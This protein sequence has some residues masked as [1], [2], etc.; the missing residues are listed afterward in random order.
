MCLRACRGTDCPHIH[1]Y[2]PLPYPS[3]WPWLAPL[4]AGQS[5]YPPL[6]G[7]LC[8]IFWLFEH[9]SK[10]ASKKHR[11][12]EENILFWFPKTHPKPPPNRIKIDVPKNIKIFID[13]RWIFAA[14]CKSRTLI[15][16]R[17]AMV[18][19]GFYTIHAFAFGMR[20]GSQNPAPNPSK[21]RPEPFKH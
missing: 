9:P 20:F 11:K 10:F 21:T 18:L 1:E 7:S 16:V 17:M 6:G 4:L 12:N 3:P 8:A 2:Q 5:T 13:F 14:C 19:L 15:F